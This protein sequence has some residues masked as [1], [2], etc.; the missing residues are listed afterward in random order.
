M[1]QTHDSHV[2]EPTSKVF[3]VF[4]FVFVL[5]LVEVF[6]LVEVMG[7]EASCCWRYLYIFSSQ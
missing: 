3:V 4:V 7:V 2:P 6:V 5:V 1:K